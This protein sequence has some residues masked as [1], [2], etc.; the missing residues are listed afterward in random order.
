M[1][2]LNTE[3]R[4]PKYQQILETI[5]REILSGRYQPGQKLPS[6]AALV[7]RFG[8][9]RITVGRALRELR[10]AG[11]IQRRAWSGT[12]LATS[13]TGDSGLLFGLL[14]PNLAATEI[15]GPICQGMSEA[16]Q[17]RKNALL[18]GNITPDPGTRGEQAWQLCQQYIAKNVAGIFFAPL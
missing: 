16:P 7:R 6:E 14:I 18:W 9:S 11:L 1:S 13:S 3:T 2:H 5:Q 10:H 4:A 17:A 15:F 8:T 12:Y